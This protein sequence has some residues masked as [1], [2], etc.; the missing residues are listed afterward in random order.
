MQEKIGQP[1]SSHLAD[2]CVQVLASTWGPTSFWEE[3][4]LAAEW[5][6]GTVGV[7][8]AASS[9]SSNGDTIC[10]GKPATMSPAFDTSN[11]ITARTPGR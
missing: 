2:A 5:H 7:A 8:E 9:S 6:A 11:G 10:A 4:V 1:L 3:C